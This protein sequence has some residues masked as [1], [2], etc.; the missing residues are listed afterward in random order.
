M[1]KFWTYSILFLLFILEGTVFQF[2]SVD[3]FYSLVT[4]VPHFVLVLIVFISIFQDR[5]KGLFI[6]LIF[7]FLYD[8][9]YGK[10]I[11]INLMG[12]ALVGYFSGWL[13]L[14]FQRSFPLYVMIET[15][16]IFLFELYSFGTLRLFQLIDISLKWAFIQVMIP[17]VIVNGIFAIL[18]FKPFQFLIEEEMIEDKV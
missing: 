7:G 3:Y 5:K 18:I 17:T 15:L 14:Y 13:T 6:G 12:M 16:T 2:L 4:I 10:M 1:Q 9:V 8:V 11:G